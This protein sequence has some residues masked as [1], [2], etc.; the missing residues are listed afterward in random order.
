MN[1][2]GIYETTLQGINKWG[3]WKAFPEV[4]SQLINVGKLIELENHHFGYHISN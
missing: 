3:E 2:K 4:F 1:K